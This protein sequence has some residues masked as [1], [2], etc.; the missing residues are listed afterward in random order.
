MTLQQ[1][2]KALGDPTRH[3]I[4]RY[5]VDASDRVD[6]AEIT[7]RFGLNH[8]AIRQHLVKLVD[9]RLVIRTTAWASG[10]GRPRLLYEVD[11]AADARWGAGG[12]YQ[13]LCLLLVEML[14]TGD[15]AVDVGRRAGRDLDLRVPS[16]DLD[17]IDR[18]GDATAR[19]GF[20]PKLTRRED[21]IEFVLATCPFADI[22]AADPDTICALHLGL[23]HGLADQLDG[24]SVAELERRNPKRGGCRLRFH[25]ETV[26]LG[27]QAS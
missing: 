8:N 25:V 24:V 23:A 7:A 13:R 11:P 20:D 3:G 16:G 4:F 26:A 22:A 21:R 5:L 6:V 17:V 19:G 9:A 14:N 12:P 1:Q 27:T 18:L 2:A 10:P 15:T